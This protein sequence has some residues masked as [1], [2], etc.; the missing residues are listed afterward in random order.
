MKITPITLPNFAYFESDNVYTGSQQGFRFRVEPQN[1]QFAACVWY[2]PYCQE[3]SEI[4][5]SQTFPLDESGRQQAA[6]WL[7][8][9]VAAYLQKVSEGTQPDGRRF[10]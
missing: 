9:Q 6:D 4:V 3:K 1:G 8:E 5:A 10:Y 2:G 7:T